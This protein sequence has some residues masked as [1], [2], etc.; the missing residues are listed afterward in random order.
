MKN[1]KRP[2]KLDEMSKET[3]RRILVEATRLFAGQGYHG[4]TMA[5]IA[6]A[7]G[8]T[9]GA[10]FHQFASKEEILYAVVDRLAK[11]F[12]VYSDALKGPG[13]DDPFATVLEVMTVHFRKQPEATV[14]LA[15]LATEFA[16]SDAPILEKIRKV[17][18]SFVDPFTLV[19]KDRK[20]VNDPRSAAIAFIGAVQGIAIQGLLRRDD[21]PM[22][23]LA[24]A[25][26]KMTPGGRNSAPGKK[27]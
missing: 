10:I 16:G 8:K 15:V 24:L 19:L 13:G 21:P 4:T 6:A 1:G 12:R 11:G 5:D 26:N 20:D 25:F 17:Y 18:D 9:Q 7:I 3:R 27:V 22:E 2:N 23:E 14:C